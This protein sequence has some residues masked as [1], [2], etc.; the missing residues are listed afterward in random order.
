MV[1]VVVEFGG[2]VGF[3][4]GF[5]GVVGFEVGFEV[6]FVFEFGFGFVVEVEVGVK[7]G[8]EVGFGVKGVITSKKG[9]SDAQFGIGQRSVPVMQLASVATTRGVYDA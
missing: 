8:F 2:V 4:V 3:E 1:E 5:E 9:S 7:V 6:V